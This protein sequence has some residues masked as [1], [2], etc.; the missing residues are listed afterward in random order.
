MGK[1]DGGESRAAKRRRKNR[2]K[3]VNSEGKGG[4]A[5]AR[6]SSGVEFVGDTRGDDTVNEE[7]EVIGQG[8]GKGEETYEPYQYRIR[9]DLGLG[10]L[11]DLEEVRQIKSRCRA[12]SLLS[13]L[14]PVDEDRD[15]FYEK[16]WEKQPALKTVD[17]SASSD[18]DGLLSRSDYVHIVNTQTFMPGE[19]MNGWK[20]HD[21]LAA[22]E[23]GARAAV[24]SGTPLAAPA[25]LNYAAAGW[26]VELTYPVVHDDALWRFMSALEHEFD[27]VVQCRVYDVPQFA[28]GLG[29]RVDNFDSFL[30]CSDGCAQVTVHKHPEGDELPREPWDGRDPLEAY[31]G[32]DD[33]PF[34]GVTLKKGECMYVPKGWIYSIAGTKEAALV[35][36]MCTNMFNATADI[37][38]LLLPQALEATIQSCTAARKSLPSGYQYCMGVSGSDMPS[39]PLRRC[40]MSNM[41]KHFALVTEQAASLVDAATD[42][43]IKN[44]M[45]QRLPVPVSSKEEEFTV[46]G[47]GETAKINVTSKLRMLRPGIARAIVEEGN[48]VLYHCMDNSRRTYGEPIRP[49]EFELDDGPAI[50][51]LLATYPTA[52]AVGDIPH[53]SEELEDK[54]DIARALF[55]EG[56]LLLDAPEGGDGSDGINDDDD[57]DDEDDNCEDG[58]PF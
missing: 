32:D 19:D 17:S 26:T 39:H 13:L 11:L 43:H 42:Q 27:S 7:T 48:V 8:E 12:A 30:M 16:Y 40:L 36:H 54:C 37:M 28:Q 14:I 22:M 44:F 35:L 55:K 56:F 50:E 5:S 6:A 1:S 25:A 41:K 52:V 53:P 46:E 47:K 2:E 49:L 15:N 10:A 34:L 3:K 31:G 20:G 58:D 23:E 57:D 38:E 29:R 33:K 24:E 21:A 51:R 18:F 9:R 45:T 4:G